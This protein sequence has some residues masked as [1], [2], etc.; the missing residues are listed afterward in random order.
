[1]NQLT[2]KYQYGED[3]SEVFRLPEFYAQIT[4]AAVR[5]AAQMYLDTSRYVKVILQ[6][7]R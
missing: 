7:E 2:Y 3:P 6:P 5:D 1:L 4:P